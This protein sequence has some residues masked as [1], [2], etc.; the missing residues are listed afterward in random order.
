MYTIGILVDQAS[1]MEE[2]RRAVYDLSPVAAV[3]SVRQA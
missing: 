3:G 1:D 2:E